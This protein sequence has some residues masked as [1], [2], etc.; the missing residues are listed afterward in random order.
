MSTQIKVQKLA[1]FRDYFAE[2]VKV[3]EYVINI[4]K[5]YLRSMVMSHW[6]PQ[7]L[8]TAI[9]LLANWVMKRK[10]YF[11]DLKI[12]ADEISCLNTML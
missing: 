9:F 10:N 7:L 2:D 6:K 1:G 11:I 12:K 3:R 5:K 8:K 4:F